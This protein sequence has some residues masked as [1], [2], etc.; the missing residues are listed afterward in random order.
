M[1]NRFQKIFILMFCTMCAGLFSACDFSVSKEQIATPSI[2]VT[3]GDNGNKIVLIDEVEHASS[4][5]IRIDGADIDTYNTYL[6][7]TDL[8]SG[9][10]VYTLSA[11]ANAVDGYKSSAFSEAITYSA[12]TT[13]G[14]PTAK[15]Y[16]K[17][18]G[19]THDVSA[20]NYT[21]TIT[22]PD[23]ET[24]TRTTG[25]NR[26]DFSQHLSSAGV[27]TFQVV[28][29]S[30]KLYVSSSEPSVAVTYTHTKQFTTPANLIVNDVSGDVVLSFVDSDNAGNY[31][32]NID[33]TTYNIHDD[34]IALNSLGHDF[35]TAKRYYISVKTNAQAD[36]FYTASDY[37]AEVY[38]DKYVE[39]TAPTDCEVVDNDDQILL[40]WSPVNNARTYSVYI[41]DNA[42]A[43]A[44]NIT[45]TQLALSKTQLD[46]H[47][48]I[49]FQVQ[50]EGYDNYLTSLKSNTAYF[51]YVERLNAPTDLSVDSIGQ[52]VILSWSAVAGASEYEVEV[53]GVVVESTDD[54]SLVLNPH[55]LYADTYT[56]RVRAI[57]ADTSKAESNFSGTIKY[58]YVITLAH[59]TIDRVAVED[60]EYYLYFTAN[61]ENAQSYRIFINN[62]L[63]KIDVL[64]SPVNITGLLSGS[65]AY[66]V[67][68]Q[69]VAPSASLYRDSQN[70]ANYAFNYK[71]PLAM[72]QNIKV[73]EVNG[74]LIWDAVTGADKYEIYINQTRFE[75]A[76]NSFD[77]E[78][79]YAQAGEYTFKVRALPAEDSYYVVGEYNEITKVHTITLTAPT[80]LQAYVE[81][82]GKAYISFDLVA[83]ADYYEI[84]IT[85]DL[86]DFISPKPTTTTSPYE[87][88]QYLTEAGKYTIYIQ[89]I[90]SGYYVSS[91]MSSMVQIE[92]N[93]T[94]SAPTGIGVSKSSDSESLY[95]NFTPVENAGSYN[96]RINGVEIKG[97]TASGYDIKDYVDFEG[98]YYIEMQ[99]VGRGAYMDSEYGTAKKY[100]HVF[101]T[102]YDYMRCDVFMYGEDI[103]YYMDNYQEFK[104]A[105]WFNY[106]YGYN[107]YK[108]YF[109]SGYSGFAREL[110]AEYG[111]YYLEYYGVDITSFTFDIGDTFLYMLYAYPEYVATYYS[112]TADIMPHTYGANVYGC[113]YIDL[114]N[115]NHNATF[116]A[117]DIAHNYD[118]HD[119]MMYEYS[120]FTAINNPYQSI[121]FIPSAQ[122]DRTDN[123]DDFAINSRASV[124]VSNT[125]QLLMAVTYGKKPAFTAS[126]SVAQTVYN[127]AKYILRRIVNS[128]YTD[129][130]KVV[131]IYDWLTNQTVYDYDI[132]MFTEATG[133]GGIT[134]IGQYKDFYLEGVL[135]NLNNSVAVCDGIAKAFVLLCQIEGIDAYKCNGIAGTSTDK[136]QWGNHAWNKVKVDGNWYVLDS[137]WDDA[138]LYTSA[139]TGRYDYILTATHEYF[140]RPDSFMNITHQEVYP[141]RDD[142]SCVYDYGH[143]SNS[144]YDYGY[145]GA[146]TISNAGQTF[147]LVIG[148]SV[149]DQNGYEIY[150]YNTAVNEMV[151][152]LEYCADNDIHVIDFRLS[153]TYMASQNSYT[154]GAVYNNYYNFV[155]TAL[156]QAGITSYVVPDSQDGFDR[157]NN[158][159]YLIIK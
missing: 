58:T 77:I 37:S 68:V 134:T 149:V 30:S 151:Q 69:A 129:Y 117:D 93:I 112:A 136:T 7:C 101:S 135:Y 128:S 60:N 40:S 111:D 133:D 57:P 120:T 122:R 110:Q 56:M 23:S 15:V 39:L 41:N 143:S 47:G 81:D 24:I 115:F 27:Y 159:H 9:A 4:Y 148:N 121:N 156:S 100:T 6:D 73:D 14:T 99:S 152:L 119:I 85:K 8:L 54:T 67:S 98:E 89:A 139:V 140:L 38:F 154:D 83:H 107:D 48:Q 19:W 86:V 131:A 3:E 145:H 52:N 137:T 91:S 147:D 124:P 46:A 96:A 65:G 44:D 13:L 155:T 104:L 82:S 105:V 10:K 70:S 18:L 75:S 130:Q 141:L 5:T 49:S 116:N 62:S 84:N 142:V 51:Q 114:M 79:Y 108:L 64:R 33:G 63:A 74:L 29:N 146:T 97:I 102:K 2:T 50:T 150:T 16:D 127:N 53:D 132:I 113:E 42:I 94:L 80:N 153:D 78:E 126:A 87:I 12:G 118:P 123:F 158:F 76:T 21:V 59:P 32:V 88:T 20:S 72:V 71:T 25:S 55:F 103:D 31:T 11:R 34:T 26:Y 61:D 36:K 138:V 22:T 95:L 35:T 92:K 106:L 144:P 66:S 1:K 17:V 157:T 45:A 125:E 90:G 43:Y 109:P 28:A